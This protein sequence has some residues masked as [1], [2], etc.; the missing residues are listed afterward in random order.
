MIQSFP[1]LGGEHAVPLIV[2]TH[3]KPEQPWM[4]PHQIH[5]DLV[6]HFQ[7]PKEVRFPKIVSFCHILLHTHVQGILIEIEVQLPLVLEVVEQQTFR[8]AGPLGDSVRRC[9]FKSVLSEFQHGAVPDQ[10]L[11]F[12]REVEEFWIHDAP[13]FIITIPPLTILVKA[14]GR[15]SKRIPGVFCFLPGERL[16]NRPA[17]RIISGR[18]PSKEAF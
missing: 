15:I 4:P 9:L 18:V 14:S 6:P 3:N 1:Q 5:F 16:T 10:I 13:P 2:G 11:A 7:G 17:P 12:R 8:D